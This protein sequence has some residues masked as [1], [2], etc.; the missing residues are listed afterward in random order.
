M[1]NGLFDIFNFTRWQQSKKATDVHEFQ[2]LNKINSKGGDGKKSIESTLIKDGEMH[3]N[4]KI[5]WKQKKQR[6]NVQIKSKQP[7]E[8]YL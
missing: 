8:V 7:N 1:K 5:D 4:S 6:R 2:G 3:S